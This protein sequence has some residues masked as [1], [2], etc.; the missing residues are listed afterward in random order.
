MGLIETLNPRAEINFQVSYLLFLL[1]DKNVHITLPALGQ[2][3]QML[4]KPVDL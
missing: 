1:K 3:N 4:V 2:S